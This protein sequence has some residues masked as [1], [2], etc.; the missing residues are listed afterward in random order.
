MK[1]RR[2]SSAIAACLGAAA[3]VLSA[4]GSVGETSGSG[5]SDAAA[6]GSAGGSAAGSAAGS[7]GGDSAGKYRIAL[8]PKVQGI[9]WFQ[10]M[11]EG[12][13]QYN[14]ENSADVEA[15]QIGPDTE[16]AAKQV[17]IIEDLIAQDVDAIVVVPPDPQAVAPV[18]KK[19]RD[20]GIVVVTHEAPALAETDSIDIDL[21]AFSNADFGEKMF[22]PLAEAMGGEGLLVGEVGSL[23][24]ATHMAWYNAG[25]DYL[26]KEYPDI[27]VASEQP[28]EDNNSDE[29]AR[30]NAQEI[31]R[32]YPDLKGFVG[33]SV[34]ALSNFAAVLQEKDNTTVKASGLSLPSIAGPYLD[35]KW[36]AHAQTWDPAGAGYASV[37]IARM[38]LDGE[39][40]TSGADLGYEGYDKVE[41]D[42]KAVTGSATL[43]LAAGQFPDGFPF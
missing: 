35:D 15:W 40:L 7:A 5:S 26:K 9:S 22:K 2:K 21:E 29:T 41:V 18:L 20:K 30:S 27:K 37:A 31:L 6:G 1:T 16:D 11:E 8:V 23:T 39:K 4:C 24:S 25:I 38:L 13:K 43:E 17:A 14:E 34:S 33:T 28:Y 32:A 10:R 36:I 12:V 3:L 42:G 19:A